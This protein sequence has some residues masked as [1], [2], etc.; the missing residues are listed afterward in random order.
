MWIIHWPWISRR[1]AGLAELIAAAANR[2]CGA[3]ME[4]A[5]PTQIE[6]EV[7]DWFRTWL[8]MPA[9]TAGLLVTGGSAANLTALLV[10]REAAGGP[11]PRQLPSS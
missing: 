11:A 6:L 2:Y 4:S 1:C 7:I 8:G 3:W 5:G 9:T 10:A